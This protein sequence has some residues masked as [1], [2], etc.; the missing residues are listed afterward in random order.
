M[1]RINLLQTTTRSRKVGGQWDVHA[2]AAAAA[3][4]VVFVLGGC[5]YYSGALED[6]IQLKNIEKRQ[7]RNQI[8]S[9]KSQLKKVE[10]FEKKKKLLEDKNRIIEQLE[11]RRGGPVKV[12]DEISKGL[13]P[14]KLWLTRLTVKGKKVTLQGKALEN[15]DVVGFVNNLRRGEVFEDINLGEI[16]AKFDQKVRFFEFSLNLKIKG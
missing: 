13:D 9:L 3:V 12:L 1:I 5:F 15:D 11:K 7:K 8:N 6:E 4:L 16:R 2:E 10:D 14:L